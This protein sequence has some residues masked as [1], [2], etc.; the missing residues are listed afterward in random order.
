[1]H[2][3]KTVELIRPELDIQ[4]RHDNNL[5]ANEPQ[6]GLQLQPTWLPLRFSHVQGEA[7]LRGESLVLRKVSGDHGKLRFQ[8][9]GIGE[10]RPMEAGR[11]I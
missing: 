7:R 3:F 1:M 6:E 4:V 5:R 9:N 8:T 11:S 2:L 10:M